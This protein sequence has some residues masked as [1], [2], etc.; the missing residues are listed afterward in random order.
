MQAIFGS[1]E[2][3]EFFE[4]Q[5]YRLTLP[6]SASSIVIIKGADHDSKKAAV[7]RSEFAESVERIIKLASV[8]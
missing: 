4:S 6:K 8:N 5:K 2:R 3:N 7:L 1:E